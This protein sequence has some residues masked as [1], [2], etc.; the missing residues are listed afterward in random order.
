[1]FVVMGV[2]DCDWLL[3]WVWLVCF[4][5]FIVVGIVGVRKEVFLGVILVSVFV[6]VFIGICEKVG[7]GIFIIE[8]IK[9]WL[10]LNFCMVLVIRL[11]VRWL[12]IILIEFEVGV[13]GRF[14]RG[15]FIYKKKKF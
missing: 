5:G 12:G 14:W 6:V 10:V 9:G 15:F 11:G 3:L 13:I 7:W 2:C 1:M 4:I 8:V